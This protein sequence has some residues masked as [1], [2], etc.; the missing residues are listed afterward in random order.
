MIPATPGAPQTSGAPIPAASSTTATSRA[1]LTGTT[2]AATGRRRFLGCSRS[3]STSMTSLRRYVPDDTRHQAAKAPMI[4]AT[5]RGVIEM[6]AAPGAAKTRT[7]LIHC[8]GRAVRSSPPETVYFQPFGSTT[9][10]GAS[11]A[12]SG[13]PS[14]AGGAGG[15][16]TAG[17]AV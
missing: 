5:C 6:P 13:G 10:A 17:A 15:A 11:T 14:G 2:P 7:F 3:A 8:R 4:G 9:T 12:A 16:P 1:V